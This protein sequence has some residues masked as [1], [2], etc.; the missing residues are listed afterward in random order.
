MKKQTYYRA[1]AN[2]VAEPHRQG[3]QLLDSSK[4]LMFDSSKV[5]G[6]WMFAQ[7]NDYY[8][9]C[10]FMCL[11]KYLHTLVT[12]SAHATWMINGA[13]LSEMLSNA[14]MLPELKLML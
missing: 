13:A 11:D 14:L 12:L 7:V 3:A 5:A 1:R 4:L 6:F 9:W 8:G 2:L 10:L